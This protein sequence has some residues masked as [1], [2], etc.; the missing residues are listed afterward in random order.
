MTYPKYLTKIREV[1]HTIARQEDS[2]LQRYSGKGVLSMPELAFVH[3]VVKELSIRSSEIFNT[4]NI[5]WE[6]N[7]NFGAG[8]TD[9]I[10]APQI[11]QAKKV[12]FEFKLG[13]D[14][15][16]W[17]NDIEKMKFL[18]SNEYD[19]IFVA[20]IDVFVNDLPT[21]QRIIDIDKRPDTVRVGNNFDFFTT[22]ASFITQTC[23]VVGTWFIQEKI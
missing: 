13:G 17:N 1:I 14:V 3:Q 22:D 18:D 6:M 8:L 5:N 19:R 11:D 15:R 2:E 21:H 16:K 23:C 7:K 12:A 20:L 4:C 9:L 10:I